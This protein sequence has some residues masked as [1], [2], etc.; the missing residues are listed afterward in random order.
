[1]LKKDI[2]YQDLDGNSLTETFWFNL[3]KAEIAK[4]ELS[5]NGGGLTGYLKAIV[6]A[7][8]GEA[9]VTTFE[10]ILTKAYGIRNADNK[11]FDKSPEISKHFM[12]TDAYSVLFMELVT[13]AEASSAFIR[14]IVPADLSEKMDDTVL[15][16]GMLP[17]S[18]FRL[19][20]VGTDLHSAAETVSAAVETAKTSNMTLDEM[21]AAIRKAEENSQ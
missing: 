13:D 12:S 7:E 17:K 1:M 16:A 6:E 14:G 19:E 5:K 2:T 21:K 18:D 11:G 4:M 20:S 9:I 10:E 8:D 3:S 15:P